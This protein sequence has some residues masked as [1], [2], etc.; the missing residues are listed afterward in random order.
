MS[1]V[2]YLDW[3]DWC[4]FGGM[5]LLS[6]A[7]GVYFAFFS[8]KKQD[9][10]SE[11][12]M[13]GRTMPIFPISMSLIA[14]YISG[15]T[16]LGTPA[17]IYVY[18]SQAY[19]GVISDILTNITIVIV[20][21]PV[22]F[23]LQVTSSYEYLNRRF[24][25]A[26]RL[27]GTCLFLIKMML[28]IPI[29]VYVPALAFSQVTGINLHL[30]SPIVCSVCIFYTSL[31]GLKAVVW[32][33]TL[34]MFLMMGGIVVV[35]IIGIVKVGGLGIVYDRAVETSRAEFFNTDL[36]PTVRHT[37]WNMLLGNY[38]YHVATMAVNQCMVQRCLS[39]SSIRHA[40]WAM[41]I[42]T[43][44]IF[45]IVTLCTLTGFVMHAYFFDCDPIKSKKISKADQLLP[46]FV[47]E[48]STI[49]PGLPGIF[50]SGVFSAALSTM[51]TGLNSMTG[52]IFEDMIEPW[53][54]G[55][56]E[57]ATGRVLKLVVVL[58]G[59]LCVSMVFVVEQLG[60]LFQ[61]TKSLLGITNGPLL[62][63]FTLGMFFPSAN[64]FG[65]LVGGITALCT[66]GWISLGAQ[67]VISKGLIK[68]PT[69]SVNVSGCKEPL[70][71]L[72]TPTAPS[73]L[74][75]ES[76]LEVAME[77]LYMFRISY[78]WYGLIGLFITISVGLL[79]SNL[80]PDSKKVDRDLLSPVIYRFLAE[81]KSSSGIQSVISPEGVELIAV[82]SKLKKGGEKC[83]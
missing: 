7:I 27:F 56:S 57:R 28:Y 15:I 50:L 54:G 22:F 64:A 81:D 61:M 67:S 66:M 82:D 37:L 36:D 40:K 63:L 59:I 1:G 48:T 20:Y 46:Y 4:V 23:K 30:I 21:L 39:V 35:L 76:N 71:H 38:V 2:K 51:S 26:V 6:S 25:P 79:V 58:I 32:A 44:G 60:T 3:F 83:S 41:F 5:L 19:M 31:G 9:T 74:T 62:G 14:S 43:A 65:A 53:T 12:L 80:R 16:L 70:D 11:Y 42:L 29:V 75:L 10:T 34:Q 55:L 49:M 52:V 68:F 73:I 17:E 69:K 47:M 24:G 33:D 13:G 78:M 45:C 72:F 8:K 18:G 77:P